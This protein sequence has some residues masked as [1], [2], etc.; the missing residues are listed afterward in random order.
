MFAKQYESADI[1]T[2]DKH[3]DRCAHDGCTDRVDIVQVFRRKKK[4]IGTKCIHETS[5]HDR[6]EDKPKQQQDL[7]F[8]EV[9]KYQLNRK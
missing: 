8:P 6:K 5:I 9:K 3:A 4:R 1:P 2:H 7:V